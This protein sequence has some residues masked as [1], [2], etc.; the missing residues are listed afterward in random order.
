M[1]LTD[2][3]VVGRVPSVDGGR[4]HEPSEGIKQS[5]AF[6]ADYVMAHRKFYLG[7]LSMVGLFIRYVNFIVMAGFHPV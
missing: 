3:V 6:K 1:I 2:A 4:V 7:Y 5:L